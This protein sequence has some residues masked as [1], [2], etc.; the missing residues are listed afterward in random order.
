MSAPCTCFIYVRLCVLPIIFGISFFFPTFFL[1]FLRLVFVF[2]M[3]SS[4]H[5][6][7]ILCSCQA[8]HVL[9]LG[10]R[11]VENGGDSGGRR[12]NVDKREYCDDFQ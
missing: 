11:D 8:Y 2:I 12:K 7:L 5:F 9:L 4:E 6:L 1:S 3:I 10:W